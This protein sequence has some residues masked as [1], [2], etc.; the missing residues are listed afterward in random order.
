MTIPSLSGAAYN[1]H[2]FSEKCTA[3]GDIASN[4]SDVSLLV[5]PDPYITTTAIPAT[6]QGVNYSYTLQ[7][8]SSSPNV[9]WSISSGALPQGLYLNADTGVISGSPTRSGNS[10]SFTV[11]AKANGKTNTRSF[12]MQ[13]N[14]PMKIE[15]SSN[16]TTGTG[17][18][19][20]VPLNRNVTLTAAINQGTPP[21]SHYQW[22]VNSSIINGATELTYKIP[23]A[24]VGTFIYIFAASDIVGANAT[25]DVTVVV[26]QP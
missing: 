8:A 17:N 3:S 6:T 20:E 9:T 26:R 1:L 13:V 7:A 14:P 5:Y 16:V 2:F 11:Q 25:A 4:F 22:M 23:T 12:T 24:N 15:I 21:Y 18:N 19:I 10:F